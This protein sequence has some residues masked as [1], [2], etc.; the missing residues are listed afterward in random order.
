MGATA[1][2]REHTAVKPCPV[3]E[4]MEED[5]FANSLS[6]PDLQSSAVLPIAQTPRG[7]RGQESPVNLVQEDQ[8]LAPGR[9]SRVP[10]G[11]SFSF[12]SQ[13]SSDLTFFFFLRPHP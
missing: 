1:L 6:C 5:K 13:S 11:F 4:E 3:R 12:L 2:D 9:A 10:P 7:A 8:S